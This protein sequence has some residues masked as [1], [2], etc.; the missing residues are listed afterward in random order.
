MLGMNAVALVFFGCINVAAY[1]LCK[2]PKGTRRKVVR[3]LCAVLLGRLVSMTAYS[4]GYSSPPSLQP[5][6]VL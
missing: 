5:I 6:A 2:C 1:Q 4:S 3:I